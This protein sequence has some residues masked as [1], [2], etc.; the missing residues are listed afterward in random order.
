MT[1]KPQWRGIGW[2][3]ALNAPHV[4]KKFLQSLS[5][6]DLAEYILHGNAGCV[7]VNH[8]RAY[9]EIRRMKARERA[10]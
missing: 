1:D 5:D 10:A 6:D 9:R 7:G 4:S 2:A 3:A 8:G